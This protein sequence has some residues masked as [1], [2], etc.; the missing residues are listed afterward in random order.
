MP[1]FLVVCLFIRKLS[2]IVKRR[3]T[4]QVFQICHSPEAMK[5]SNQDDQLLNIVDVPRTVGPEM[6]TRNWVLW[7]W[8]SYFIDP[9]YKS[10]PM[11]AKR[12]LFLERNLSWALSPQSLKEPLDTSPAFICSLTTAGFWLNSTGYWWNT[13]KS[14]QL[15]FGVFFV[16]A[17]EE[18]CRLITTTL[19]TLSFKS[20]CFQTLQ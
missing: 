12:S 2:E 3:H 14:N 8:K 9:I 18:Y 17:I 16:L 10:N 5:S 11:T 13:Y 7:L 6:Q 15:G 20:N 19:T 4:R 1:Q